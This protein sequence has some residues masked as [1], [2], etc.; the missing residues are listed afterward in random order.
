MDFPAAHPDCGGVVTP[1][2]VAHDDVPPHLVCGNVGRPAG[3]RGPVDS[4][5]GDRQRHSGGEGLRPGIPG[6]GD[7]AERR[8]GG[9]CA[10]D[11]GRP[12]DCPL[13]AVGAANTE[14]ISGAQH[15]GGWLSGV[16]RRH[17][18]WRVCG[19]ERVHGVAYR[20]GVHGGGHAGAAAA[21]YVVR[22]TGVRSHK[23]PARHYCP[24][25]SRANTGWAARH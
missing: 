10:N 22:R 11:A 6:S 15:W 2:G 9:V 1:V 23:Y 25:E 5:G 21:R 18:H 7:A 8:P 24:A 4:R 12:V 13:P 20:G 19:H 3:R 14:H 16:A 17:E